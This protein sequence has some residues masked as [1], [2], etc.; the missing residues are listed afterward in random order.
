MG[1][2]LISP[3]FSLQDRNAKCEIPAQ[4]HAL[5]GE[6]CGVCLQSPPGDQGAVTLHRRKILPLRK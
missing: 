3:Q 5:W 6:A 4:T 1:L 2:S